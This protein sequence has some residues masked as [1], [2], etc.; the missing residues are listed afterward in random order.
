[1]PTPSTADNRMMSAATLSPN[2]IV[3]D[4]I[5]NPRRRLSSKAG[6]LAR[7]P[8]RI[9]SLTGAR[10]FR[11]SCFAPHGRP[12]GSGDSPVLNFNATWNAAPGTAD[13]YE[14]T[15]AALPLVASDPEPAEALWVRGGRTGGVSC[16]T[17]AQE[18]V[19]R[20]TRF[21]RAR[22]DARQF[23]LTHEYRDAPAKS[24]YRV[25]HPVNG[26]LAQGTLS[27]VMEDY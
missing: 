4:A 11:R 12:A 24:A 25:W 17:A 15:R 14:L 2:A 3:R 9:L 27:T 6:R 7:R 22:A 19:R 20:K 5:A 18:P 1:M 8:A 10:E 13:A 26:G 16:L 23:G 21:E